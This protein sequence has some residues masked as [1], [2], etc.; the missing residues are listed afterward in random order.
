MGRKEAGGKGVKGGGQSPVLKSSARYKSRQLL[1]CNAAGAVGVA[2]VPAGGTWHCSAGAGPLHRALNYKELSGRIGVRG[3]ACRRGVW[4]WGTVG[5]EPGAR[6]G[7]GVGVGG[8]GFCLQVGF[9]PVKAS[10]TC[11]SDRQG[12]SLLVQGSTAEFW[13]PKLALCSK[14]GPGAFHSVG[15]RIQRC[16]VA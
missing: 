6:P 3:R 8:R 13:S 5:G 12:A 15:L 16:Q 9:S 4:R 7:A 1:Q 14:M 10:P 11:T 2:P